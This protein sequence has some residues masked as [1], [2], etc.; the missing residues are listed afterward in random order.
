MFWILLFLYHLPINLL[1][2]QIDLQMCWIDLNRILIFHHLEM[3]LDLMW[4]VLY[5]FLVVILFIHASLNLQSWKFIC[6]LF[7]FSK[8]IW[9]CYWNCNLIS[10]SLFEIASGGLRSLS[11]EFKLL[12]HS[13]LSGN[14]ILA[15]NFHKFSFLH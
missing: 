15:C 2:F 3:K 5:S 1:L 6:K 8:L 7:K 13:A 11:S 10:S 4:L 9:N 12:C 14:S